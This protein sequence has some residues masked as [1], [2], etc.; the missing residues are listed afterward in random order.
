MAKYY[1][2]KDSI[3]YLQKK[4]IDFVSFHFKYIDHFINETNIQLTNSLNK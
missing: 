3:Q 1:E 2:I 4:K